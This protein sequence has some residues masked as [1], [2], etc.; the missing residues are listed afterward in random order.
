M[1]PYSLHRTVVVPYF[2]FRKNDA[3][4]QVHSVYGLPKMQNL[5]QVACS[6]VVTLTEADIPV[7]VLSDLLECHTVPELLFL[8]G[9]QNAYLN[10]VGDL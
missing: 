10:L 6:E 7:A 2:P 4:V 9:R 1:P 5:D 3:E 8:W